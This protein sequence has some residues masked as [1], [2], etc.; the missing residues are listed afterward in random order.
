MFFFRRLPGNRNNRNYRRVFGGIFITPAGDCPAPF[1]SPW[2]FGYNVGQP[3][4]SFRAELAKTRNPGDDRNCWMKTGGSSSQ[5]RPWGARINSGDRPPSFV[6]HFCNIAGCSR[7]FGSSRICGERQWQPELPALV[8]YYE[9]AAVWKPRH[10]RPGWSGYHRHAF[11]HKSGMIRF[12]FT[13]R[14]IYGF[15]YRI[16]F[17]CITKLSRNALVLNAQDI[18]SSVTFARLPLF[19]LWKNRS[20]FVSRQ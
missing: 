4:P 11:S 5:A 19:F 7:F 17:S 9:Y 8:P 1:G 18:Y 6:E 15:L 16:P 20:R 10:A 13:N 12:F 14:R 3:T 2:G